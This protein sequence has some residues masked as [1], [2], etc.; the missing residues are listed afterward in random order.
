MARHLEVIAGAYH[1][2]YGACRIVPVS[3]RDGGPGEITDLNRTR[4]WLNEATAQVLANGLTIL[5][6]SAPERM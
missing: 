1:S 2:W 5:G 6:I 4:L 3:S